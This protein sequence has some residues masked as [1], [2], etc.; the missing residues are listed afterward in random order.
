M[1]MVLRQHRCFQGHSHNS[2]LDIFV[3]ID[4]NNIQI[5]VYQLFI[6][7]PNPVTPL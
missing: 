1:L 3:L 6:F 5:A 2:G 7:Q 4:P